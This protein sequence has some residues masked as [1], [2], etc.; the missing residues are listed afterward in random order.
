MSITSALNSATS[1]LIASSR[2]A[3]VTA[4]NV[5]NALTEGYAR[6]ELLL[7]PKLLGQ[8]GA[9]V[10]VTGIARHANAV[11][12]QD[13]RL[14]TADQSARALSYDFLSRMEQTL[15]T[16]DQAGS[17]SAGIAALEQSLIAAAG[18]PES[19]A[20][21]AAVV[22]AA[23]AVTQN[24]GDI[25]GMI[26][27]ERQSADVQ[28][29]AEV[30][31]LN[32]ALAGV[33]DMNIRIRAFKSTGR[34]TSTLMDQRQQMID[35]IS[36]I[37]PVKEVARDFD[38]V[39]LY[40]KSGTIILESRPV[41]FGFTKTGVITP[42][43]TLASGALSGLAMNGAPIQTGPNGGRLGEGSLSALFNL[44]DTLAPE[45]QTKIDAIAR[46]MIERVTDPTVDPTLAPGMTGLFTDRGNAF[47]PLDEVGLAE[48]IR[49]NTSVVPE[50]GG[51]L[52][53]LREGLGATSAGSGGL[54]DRL[55][56]LAA[57]LGER[58]VQASGGLSAGARSLAEFASE[59]VSSQSSQ[60]L[61]AETGTAFAT[62]RRDALKS[63]MLKDGVDT[64]QEMQNLLLI[65][66][67]YAANAKVIQTVD[68]M[69]NVLLGL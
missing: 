67:A 54:S 7:A 43:M 5:S 38:Q 28:I 63:E 36:Q 24:L 53:R 26:Q 42:D 14:S 34:D 23:R 12:L 61:S 44:R 1:G 39:A 62:A 37:V 19:D 57:A 20:R 40:T 21:L 15:G 47:D 32:E 31:R 49:L 51:D 35:T 17:L 52:W 58:R 8:V 13:L 64:D 27:S 30:K 66:K 41:Q 60:R 3:E 11:L 65:E 48:R 29:G 68:E 2:M 25:S 16:P 18:R 59:V 69:I 9:G 50:Q 46:D 33:A 55:T 45:A 6:R 56:A 4:S 22:D 10:A